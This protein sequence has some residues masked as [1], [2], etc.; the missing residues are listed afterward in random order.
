[1]STAWRKASRTSRSRTA[2]SVAAARARALPRPSAASHLATWARL[3]R[4]SAARPGETRYQISPAD[5]QA[6]ADDGCGEMTQDRAQAGDEGGAGALRGCAAAGGTILAAAAGH[7]VAS[8]SGAG[9]APV[10]GA[11]SRGACGACRQDR[12]GGRVV[13]PHGLED[14]P[15]LGGLRG[16]SPRARWPGPA[17]RVRSRP[18]RWTGRGSARRPRPRTCRPGG[19]SSRR[20]R[21]WRP[22]APRGTPGPTA[23]SSRPQEANRLPVGP[24]TPVHE[25]AE[26]LVPAQ[27]AVGL[28]EVAPA[29]HLDAPRPALGHE[30]LEELVVRGVVGEVVD[31]QAATREGGSGDLAVADVEPGEDDPVGRQPLRVEAIRAVPREEG[32]VLGVR[33]PGEVDPLDDPPDLVAED[34]PGQGADPSIPGR[35][36]EDPGR[37]GPDVAALLGPEPV[38]EDRE[39][40][41]DA[42]RRPERQP[43]EDPRARAIQGDD[44]LL[45]EPWPGRV[46]TVGRPEAPTVRV[47]RLGPGRRG[48]GRAVR[49]PG[50]GCHLAATLAGALARVRS[51]RSTTFSVPTRVSLSSPRMNAS[52]RLKAMSSWS[53]AGGLFM[54]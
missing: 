47:A 14:A 13:R 54:K 12:L 9:R 23:G 6:P 21:W 44:R 30:A 20:E 33:H 25:Q 49:G 38:A 37:V 8:A 2:G 10:A 46:T 28:A 51:F 53:C 26:D 32:D 7:P 24:V 50:G 41:A 4:A 16:R 42:D 11:G 18:D 39:P 40:A 17:W 22:S 5:S 35:E 45:A 36:A 1:M 3:P 48:V 52:T 27:H 43:A 29:D 34:G 31:R 15:L 19:G